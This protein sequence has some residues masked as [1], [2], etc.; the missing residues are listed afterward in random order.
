MKQAW[1]SWTARRFTLL[2]WLVLTTIPSLDH[3]SYD[4]TTS[5]PIDGT[6]RSQ[7]GEVILPRGYNASNVCFRW[8]QQSAV[9]N[10]TLYLY[11]GQIKTQ[12]GQTQNTWT[13]NFYSLD[14]T[15]NWQIAQ[16]AMSQLAQPDGPPAVALGYLWSSHQ[17][18]FLYGGEFSWQP[19]TQP[20]PLATWEYHIQS[21]SWESHS[22][23]QSSDGTNAPENNAAIQR[24]AE[25]AGVNVPALG[26]GYY[27]GGHLDGYTTP[28]WSQSIPRLY[29]QSLLEFTFP[30]AV[31][32]Q[33]NALSDD[34]TA[35]SWGNYRNITKG[36][37]QQDGGF[38]A[39]AD[40]LLLY[41]PGFG[42]Q[43]ILVALGGG[44]NET[45]V[46]GHCVRQL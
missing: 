40:G 32:D 6:G 23:P 45:F 36:G 7:D 28:G 38:T 43:G 19:V 31:N 26:R 18:L 11:G 8:A 4:T 34:K 5:A 9:V 41:V 46:S 2:C 27:F 42:K 30:G 16:P 3:N 25:G 15:N 29:L 24:A 33:V 21:Q 13:N 17:S 12:Q 39:R 44:T 20:A 37:P 14:L 22:N 1:T 10:G 35:G